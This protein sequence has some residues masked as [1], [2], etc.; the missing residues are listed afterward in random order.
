MITVQSLIACGI[1][2]TQ[3]RAFAD[4][5]VAACQKYA[6]KP[7]PEQ[8]AFIAQ[9]MHE[10]SNFTRLEENLYYSKPERICAVWP[11]RFPVLAS[12]V[13]FA[14]NPK[15]LANKV[16]GGRMGNTGPNDGF[17]Y[18]GRGA[19]Q[20]TGK[21]NYRAASDALGLD[22]VADPDQVA[23]PA[24]AAFTA[25]WFWDKTGCAEAL[26]A[27]GIDATTRVI[28]GGMV[29]AEERRKHYTE[30]LDALG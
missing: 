26:R 27:G 9:A 23:R 14:R 30:C 24:A 6:I 22:F 25:A 12:A 2:P 29:G 16:Y 15:G 1:Q 5:L 10:S 4:H 28:N 20:L 21:D 17:V 18:R 11:R 7:G 3:A 13:P 19:F 8:A